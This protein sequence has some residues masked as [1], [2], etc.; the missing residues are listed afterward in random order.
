VRA[1]SAT[2]TRTRG[3][4]L[5]LTLLASLFL[6]RVLGQVLVA[7]FDVSF[8]PSMA[9]WYSGLVPYSVLLPAQIAILLLQAKISFD[10]FRAD[11]W[12]VRPRPVVGRGL[13]WFSALYF[14]AMALRYLL[15]MA[16]YP[17]RRWLGTGTIPIVFHWVLAAYLYTLGDYHVRAETPK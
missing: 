4:A 14:T 9:E 2:V 15:T 6:L 7:S 17:E 3:H 8:L 12:F 1:D 11:G 16:W 13:R 10:F 5:V